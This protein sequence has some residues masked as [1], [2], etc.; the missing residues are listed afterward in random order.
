[1]LYLFGE[2]TLDTQRAELSRA[3]R[4]HRLRRKVFQVL[5]YLLAHADRV[6]SKQELCEQVWPEQFIS[7]AALES[8]I[9]AVRQV[10]GDNGRGQRLLRTV[11]GQG[12]RV[13]AAVTTADPALPAPPD[14]APQASPVPS[15]TFARPD[16]GLPRV[17]APGPPLTGYRHQL[18]TCLHALE[19]AMHGHPQVLLLTGDA[20][21]GKT[22]LLTEVRVLARQRGLHVYHGRCYENTTL[23]YLPFAQGLF[24][25]LT[26]APAA[27]QTQLGADADLLRRFLDLDSAF[28]P[29]TSATTFT[30]ADQDKLRLLLTVERSTRILA[31]HHPL[32]LV[33]DDLHWADRPSLDLFAHLVFSLADTAAQ[34][35]VPLV[36]IGTYR[37]VDPTE[38]LALLLRRLQRETICQTLALSGLAEAQVAEL[39]Q[40]LGVRR[41]S[42][43]LVSTV[44]TV[45]QGNPLF[46]QE[47]V[48]QLRQQGALQERRGYTVTTASLADLRLPEHVTAAVAA[49]TQRLSE[50]C[51]RLLILAA[52]LGDDVSVS[53][54]SAVSG[55][56]E[57]AVLDR[58]EEGMRQGILRGEGPGFQ[59]AHP[60]LRHVLYSTPSVARRQRLHA[61]IAQVMERLYAGNIEGH[62]LEIAHHLVSAGSVAQ[63]EKVV[64]Y[65]RRAGD[66]AC[67][68]FAW[69]EAAQYYEAALSMAEVT[70]CLSM[71]ERAELHYRAGLAYHRDQDVGP[72]LEHYARAIES[73]RLLDDTSSLARVL[74]D[75]TETQYTLASVPL[76]ALADL[77]PL[78]EGLEVLQEHEPQLCG[79]ILAVL[80]QAYRNARQGARAQALAQRAF[81]IGQEQ[82]DDDLC[83]RAGAALGLGYMQSLYVREALATW[84]QAAAAARR[85]NDLRLQGCPIARIPLSLVLL[86]RLA[87]AETVA[88]EAYELNRT[89]HEWGEGVSVALSHLACVAVARGDFV[90]ME[91]RVQETM[92][93]VHRSGYPWGGFRALLALACAQAQCGAWCEA[94]A[95]LAML[96]EPDRVFRDPGP[97]VQVF[98]RA[99]QQLVRAYAEGEKLML[100]LQV[101]DV[102]RQVSTDSYSL[103][104]LCALVELADFTTA[105]PLAEQPYQALAMAAERGVLFSSGWMFLIPRVLGVAATLFRQWDTAEAQFH[106]AL[107]TA[108]R[109]GAR[110]ELGRAY[111]D[112]AR[113]LAARRMPGDRQRAIAYMAR[114]GNIFHALNMTPFVQRVQQL[115]A[116]LQ[117]Q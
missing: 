102:L 69:R 36:I 107:D 7:D 88:L 22:R 39:L 38:R 33:I 64:T 111:L 11:Y 100:T 48:H 15:A 115:R 84:Q 101:T 25:G 12:Y 72:C 89:I 106:V 98:T 81:A 50:G 79:R 41:P 116:T 78:E 28:A 93:A 49:R 18:D 91:R 68:I 9:K 44:H 34:A 57:E 27:L 86:G 8:T 97:V 114:A 14:R 60:L 103:A 42:H 2:C 51:H 77:Q 117:L 45:T 24:A 61:Q 31:Q 108:T 109:T 16:P 70:D 23:P 40:G 71:P 54:L 74:I 62:L 26:Q 65:A 35:P 1:M 82:G 55:L 105:P 37:P 17:R 58:L 43:Q 83:A 6:V 10:I 19:E 3:G 87:E 20:G 95:T 53:L 96:L 52:C 5:V 112:Y 13:V 75:R 4:V 47:V 90:A 59:F 85:I 66:Q 80:A 32:I 113:M 63:R 30:Q 110:P 29:P 73:Y 21:M 92:A 67:R 46:I 99:L 76:G 56:A 104:P 94:E